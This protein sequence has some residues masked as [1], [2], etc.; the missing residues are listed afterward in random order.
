MTARWHPKKKKWPLDQFMQGPSR[1]MEYHGLPQV[2]KDAHVTTAGDHSM[3]SL[4]PTTP[5]GRFS[6]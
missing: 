1:S 2:F 4:L 3:R 5:G 6:K